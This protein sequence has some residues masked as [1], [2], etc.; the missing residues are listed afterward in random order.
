MP[1]NPTR[2]I[3]FRTQAAILFG[4]IVLALV[5]TLSALIGQYVSTQVRN[6][7]GSELHSVANG[8]QRMLVEGLHER[9]AIVTRLAADDELWR[10]GLD[11]AEV[12]AAL[13][14]QRLV[15]DD[16]AW[17]GVAGVDGVVRAA[18]GNLL[19][20]RDVSAR[21]W[22]A[23]GQR[24]A[25]V[26][27]VHEALLLAKLLPRDRAGE[28]QRFVDFAAPIRVGGDVRGVLALHCGWDWTNHVIETL[29]RD[30]SARLGL[31]LFIFDRTGTAIHAPR[32]GGPGAVTVGTH[33]EAIRRSDGPAGIVAWPDGRDYLTSV[34]RLQPDDPEADLGWLVVA[35]VPEDAAYAPVAR[36]VAAVALTGTV[37]AAIAVLLAWLAARSISDPLTAIARAAIDVQSGKRG[38]RIPRVGGNIELREL[39]RALVDMTEQFEARVATRT[40]ELEKANAEL[41]SMARHD[42][43]T[44][45][46]N[47]RGFEERLKYAV[48]AARRRQAPISVIAID[49]DHFKQV[50]D[51]YG[52]GVG[53]AVLIELA[54][55]MR[56]RFRE[57]DI[58]ARLGGEEFVA[59]LPDTD[60]AGAERAAHALVERVA[61]T[62]F[63]E[64]DRVTVSCGVSRLP[65]EGDS[66]GNLRRADRAL[67]RAKQEGRNRAVL[68][69]TMIDA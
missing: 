19:V 50:N 51:R 58:L 13:A 32:H 67:Y 42:P 36:T 59:L 56:E 10:H 35:R 38:A 33:V 2:S 43:M 9:L 11:A 60:V 64:V 8:A 61:T 68:H 3:R 15:K 69:E 54:A 18:T 47:R 66:L 52:H 17:M 21:P 23:A 37:V 39:S 53:D 7:I 31:E 40:R 41:A 27:D 1:A 24:G 55:V 28:P 34:V 30:D 20:G 44:G 12:R 4:A 48:A 5:V 6:R 46:L 49:V 14:Q 26:G 16:L 65:I 25:H 62:R 57:T 63:D 22:F 29:V 45:L